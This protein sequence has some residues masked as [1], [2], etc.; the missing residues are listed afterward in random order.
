MEDCQSGRMCLSRKQVWSNPP[1]V[2]IL[3]LPP[4]L[5]P[6]NNS[7]DVYIMQL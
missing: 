4:M 5:S 1:Q 3:Y 6:D 2:Q 7:G